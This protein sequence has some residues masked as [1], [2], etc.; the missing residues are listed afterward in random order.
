[1]TV[2]PAALLLATILFVAG[3]SGGGSE[4]TTTTEAA[5]TE[6]PETTTTTEAPAEAGHVVHVYVPNVGECFDRRRLQPEEG[7]GMVVLLLDCSLPHTY[8]VFAAF[9]VD[10]AALAEGDDAPA[11]GYPGE[12]PLADEAKRICPEHFED[13]VGTPYEL[14]ELEMA[15]IVP[16]EEGWGNG[17]RTIACTLYDPSS[18]RMAGT[19]QGAQR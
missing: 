16:T 18:E 19:Q 2:R 9:A 6:S 4:P 13:W 8:Q 11:E 1:M 15:W 5:A 14:S 12:D 10:E 3:C 7:A 17:D